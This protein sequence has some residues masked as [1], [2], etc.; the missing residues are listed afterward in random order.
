MPVKPLSTEA[1]ARLNLVLLKCATR[2][3]RNS[4]RR[5]TENLAREVAELSKELAE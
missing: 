3:E 4:A 5:H 2:A 1:T